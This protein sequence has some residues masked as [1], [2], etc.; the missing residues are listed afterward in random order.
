MIVVDSGVLI[1]AANVDDHY[2]SCARLIAERG[3]EFLVPSTVVVEVCWMLSRHVS[4]PLEA[5]F[6]DAIA[7]GELQL[8]VLE[9]IDYARMSE[10]VTTYADLPLGIGRC[11]R[12]RDC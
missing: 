7:E 5:D 10:L 12:C 1:A 11:L 9:Q 2:E 8:E 6:L 3:S 4:V